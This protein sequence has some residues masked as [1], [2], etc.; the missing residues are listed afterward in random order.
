M[1]LVT[2]IKAF[3]SPLEVVK[4]QQQVRP[5]RSLREIT[6]EVWG[7]GGLR[8]FARGFSATLAR[9]PLAF[10]C[11]FSSFELLTAGRKEENLWV[12]LAGG[13]AGICSWITTYPQER[14]PTFKMCL[15]NIE[16]FYYKE[17]LTHQ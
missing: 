17:R 13:L 7:V 1:T 9:E 3:E 6:G 4:I 14:P 15:Y 8:G 12:F 16:A 5:E 2:I 11:Y 10:A